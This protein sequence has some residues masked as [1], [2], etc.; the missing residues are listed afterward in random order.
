MPAVL[1]AR[2]LT[3]KRQVLS[4]SKP[5]P[6]LPDRLDANEAHGGRSGSLLQFRGL[7]RPDG[8]DAVRRGCCTLLLHRFCLLGLQI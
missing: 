7:Y 3:L 8:V 1:G 6:S 2:P 5:E 4:C